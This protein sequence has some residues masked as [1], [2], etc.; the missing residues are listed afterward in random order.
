MGTPSHTHRHTH[1]V[2]HTPSHTHRHT[3]LKRVAVAEPTLDQ[4][5]HCSIFHIHAYSSTTTTVVQKLFEPSSAQ[6]R[7]LRSHLGPIFQPRG[8]GSSRVRGARRLLI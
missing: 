1:T 7:S 6:V 3:H 2:T 8:W 5:A 4:P